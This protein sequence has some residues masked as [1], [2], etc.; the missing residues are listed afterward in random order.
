MSHSPAR[1]SQLPLLLLV[2]LA[3][4]A[5]GKSPPKQ[6]GNADTSVNATAGASIGAYQGP[7]I[8]K[9][10]VSLALATAQ[11]YC[12]KEGATCQDYKVDPNPRL[13]EVVTDADRANGLQDRLCVH[14][15]FLYKEPGGFRDG[16]HTFSFTKRTGAWHL[17]PSSMSQ[18]GFCN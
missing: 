9:D 18:G 10:L 12:Q 7:V 4:T 6:A 5:C 13:G 14:I 2:I 11:N 3:A 15:S 17:G 8:P 16:G 1:N